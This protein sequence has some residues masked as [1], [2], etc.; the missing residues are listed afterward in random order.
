MFH[1]L[2]ETPTPRVT[3]RPPRIPARN[4]A[5]F[6]FAALRTGSYEWIPACAGMTTV[7]N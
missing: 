6:E 5:S 3:A 1:T 7:S 4:A 2:A